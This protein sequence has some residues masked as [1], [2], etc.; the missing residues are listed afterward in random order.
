MHLRTWRDNFIDVVERFK[1]YQVTTAAEA[2]KQKLLLVPASA[3]DRV[4]SALR[5]IAGMRKDARD[6]SA[7]AGLRAAAA[8][9][10]W[11]GLKYARAHMFWRCFTA[12][13]TAGPSICTHCHT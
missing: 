3:K 2:A 13:P 11:A 12:N 1:K 7:R 8:A 4:C 6:Q 10:R 9:V 5:S